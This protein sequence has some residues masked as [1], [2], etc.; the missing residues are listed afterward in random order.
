ME[1]LIGGLVGAA[2]VAAPAMWYAA[3]AADGLAMLQEW[4]ELV[5][6]SGSTHV[7][8]R[9]RRGQ[10][11]RVELPEIALKLLKCDLRISRASINKAREKEEE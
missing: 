10:M 5:T 4:F 8:A 3:K 1:Y 6:A 2:V 9:N 11:V 7:M